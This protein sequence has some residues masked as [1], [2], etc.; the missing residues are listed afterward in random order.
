M[1]YQPG[2]P[3]ELRQRRRERQIMIGAVVLAGVGI[4]YLVLRAVGML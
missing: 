2:G 3:D 4:G 1:A